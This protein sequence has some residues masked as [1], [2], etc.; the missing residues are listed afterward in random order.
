M[1]SRNALPERV[2]VEPL[3]T[4][5]KRTGDLYLVEYTAVPA[6]ADKSITSLHVDGKTIVAGIKRWTVSFHRWRPYLDCH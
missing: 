3:M 5:D 1:A 4:I 6:L 2:Y